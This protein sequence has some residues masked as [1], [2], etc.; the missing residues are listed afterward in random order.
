MCL[1]ERKNQTHSFKEAPLVFQREI[2]QK[3]RR[4]HGVN[5]DITLPI[6]RQFLR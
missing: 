6:F 3:I 1:F 5:F 2:N 4:A